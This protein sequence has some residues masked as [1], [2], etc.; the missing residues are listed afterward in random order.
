MVALNF[1]KEVGMKKIL[2]NKKAIFLF[3]FPALLL[4]VVFVVVPIIISAYYSTLKWDGL[5][6]GLFIGLSNYKEIFG[7]ERFL[8]SFKNSVL[9]AALSLFVQLPFSL[10]LAIVVS[11][12]KRGEKFYRTAFFV[13]VIISSVVI[14]YL[15]QRIYNGDY[16]LLNS[17]MNTIGLKGQDWLGQENT[18]L[19][20]A[21]IPNLWQYVG[22]H[23][24]IMYAGV[25]SISTDINEAAMIDGATPVQTAFHITIPLL[26]P[27]IEVC[28]TFSLIG[29]L[30]IFDLIYVLTGGG[31]FYVTEVPTVYMFKEIFDKMHYG[32]GSAISMFIIL[33][34]LIFTFLIRLA[35]K[36]KEEA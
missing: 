3:T 22:Y 7:D 18:A 26:R 23:M 1:L 2:S 16:G 8:N 20:A 15:W 6:K 30:K 13:P 12:V 24:L 31:P 14:G 34:C 36:R 33:E 29:A 25:K 4:M 10:L 35:F 19:M 17:F 32:Y 21:F 28:V 27:I 9:Y 11:N 5:G